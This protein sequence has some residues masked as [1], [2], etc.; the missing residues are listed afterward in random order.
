MNDLGMKFPQRSWAA[1]S[2][3][4]R[5]QVCASEKTTT[6][7]TTSVATLA[8]AILAQ[9]FWFKW[10]VAHAS[11]HHAHVDVRDRAVFGNLFLVL[12]VRTTVTVAGVPAC[13]FMLVGPDIAF[14]LSCTVWF[15][16]YLPAN[17]S[18]DYLY[19]MID[20]VSLTMILWL[21]H[22]I[23]AV[24]RH[25]YQAD[26]DYWN[27]VPM[28]IVPLLLVAFFH[29]DMNERPLLHTSWMT[30]LN[31]SVMALIPQLWLVVQT[32]GKSEA[33]VSSHIIA[34]AGSRISDGLLVWTA[35]NHITWNEWIYQGISH[36][37]VAILSA[38]LLQICGR[39][40]CTSY[41]YFAPPGRRAWVEPST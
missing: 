28:V 4:L 1:L 24:D 8:Q 15:D 9:A 25:T 30:M 39:G 35:R 2:L 13:A 41:F 14:R 23:F 11:L 26:S 17:A 12:Q 7:T 32:G 20:G 21:L 33:L 22:Q 36:G 19:Q 6:K 5:R 27:F 18:G 40:N 37:I 38:H 34:M 3:L 16:G 29:A 31:G 10:H